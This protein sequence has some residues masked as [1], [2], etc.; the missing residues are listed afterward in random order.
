[1]KK[2]FL[3][4]LIALGSFTG[5]SQM[6]IAHV[7]LQKVIDTLP[8][9]KNAQKELQ[10]MMAEAE[11]DLKDLEGA[12][13]K[14]A[15]E[16]DEAMTNNG[17]QITLERIRKRLQTAQKRLVEAEEMWQKDIRLVN[18]RL[19]APIFERAQ[20]AIENVADKMKLSYVL[21]VNNTYY[22]KGDD[23]TNSVI[24]EALALDKEAALKEK[25]APGN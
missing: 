9:Y 20:K 17:S 24:T 5:F 11:K 8:S 10:S 1:M 12:Y 2:L 13:E 4:T 14:V 25:P 21:E 23:I 6:K 16:Y 19:N 7:D 22:A 15:Q 18:D 3:A